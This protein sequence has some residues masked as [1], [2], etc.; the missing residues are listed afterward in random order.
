MRGHAGH[1]IYNSLL[2]QTAVLPVTAKDA[3]KALD[4]IIV[5][6]GIVSVLI[7]NVCYL[8]AP[9]QLQLSLYANDV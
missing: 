9:P 8:G 2:R 3:S 5:M 4:A 7:V 1:D 6:I